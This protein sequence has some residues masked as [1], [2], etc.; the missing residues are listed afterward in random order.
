MSFSFAP[1]FSLTFSPWLSADAVFV[2][3]AAAAFH[4]RRFF[5]AIRDKNKVE[6]EISE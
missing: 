6:I 1:F 3:V 2:V 4:R 5:T